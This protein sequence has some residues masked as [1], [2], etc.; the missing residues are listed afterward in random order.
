VK[1]EDFSTERVFFARRERSAILRRFIVVL[2]C[3]V[4][5]TA[6]QGFAMSTTSAFHPSA[7]ELTDFSRG[8]LDDHRAAIIEGHISQCG[9]CA[10]VVAQAPGDEF[11]EQLRASR[12]APVAD[13]PSTG[14]N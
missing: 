9:Q 11:S 10:Q 2:D 4:S 1:R 3:F 6:A 5:A 14:V 13:S 8:L 7:D 12:L